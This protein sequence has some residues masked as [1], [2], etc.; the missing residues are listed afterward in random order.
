MPTP[1][2]GMKQ[3]SKHRDNDFYSYEVYILL[4]GTDN[5]QVKHLS[6]WILIRREMKQRRGV[7]SRESASESLVGRGVL[8]F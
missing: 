6:S 5:K 8:Q 3:G 1:L 2:L 4:E 7:R